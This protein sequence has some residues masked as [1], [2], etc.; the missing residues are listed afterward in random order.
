MLLTSSPAQPLGPQVTGT[1]PLRPTPAAGGIWWRCHMEAGQALLWGQPRP[2]V[3]GDASAPPPCRSD[4][5]NPLN[6]KPFCQLAKVPPD[7]VHLL[8]ALQSIRLCPYVLFTVL[9]QR[10]DRV[11]KLASRIQSQHRIAHGPRAITRL[12]V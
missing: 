3:S 11:G 4:F 10:S 12:I 9:L 5:P 7:C 1:L 2:S 8:C 6:F